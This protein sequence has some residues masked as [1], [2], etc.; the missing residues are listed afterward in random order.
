MV[1]PLLLHDESNFAPRVTKCFSFAVTGLV[2]IDADQVRRATRSSSRHDRDATPVPS[3]RSSRSHARRN[4][5]TTSAPRVTRSSIRHERDDASVPA[6]VE[7]RLSRSSPRRDSNSAARA[8]PATRSSAQLE[9]DDT[10]VPA[11]TRRRVT[12]SRSKG[13][14]IEDDSNAL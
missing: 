2:T 7:P 6:R 3:P 8:R 10:P 11:R 12:R 1:V 5:D 14:F 9:G 4:S 13:T